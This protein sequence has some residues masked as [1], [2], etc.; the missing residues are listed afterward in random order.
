MHKALYA[1]AW[2]SGEGYKEKSRIESTRVVSAVLA[3]LRTVLKQR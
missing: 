1:Y 3:A 2:N